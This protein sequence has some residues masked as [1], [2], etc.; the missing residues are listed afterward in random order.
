MLWL[1]LAIVNAAGYAICGFFDNYITDVIFKAKKQEAVKAYYG[2]TYIV[3][4]IALALIFGL[5]ST[6]MSNVLWLLLSGVLSS[7]ASIPYYKALKDE[8]TTTA[9]IFLQLTPVIYLIADGLI[10]GETITPTQLI[11]FLV[12]IAAPAVVVAMKKKKRS[13]KQTKGLHLG[14]AWLFILYV[15]LAAASGVITAH[16]GEG[17]AFTTTFAWFVLGRGIMDLLYYF[18]NPSWRKRF[19]YLEKHDG[20]RLFTTLTIAQ[21]VFLVAEFAGR[22]ALIIGVPALVSVVSNALEMVIV[23]VLGIVLS[24]LIPIFGREKLNRRDVMAHLIATI[25]AVVGIII[26][27]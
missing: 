5:Q 4:A 13:T 9:S 6:E 14:A 10:F 26:L 7:T 20:K 25:L 17:L 24:I 11:G 21:V 3:T 2:V 8:E 19:Q 22:Y 23:F 18:C 1:I 27:Q 16:A 12:V 15:I